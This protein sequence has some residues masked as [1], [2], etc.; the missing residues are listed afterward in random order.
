MRNFGFAAA[1]PPLKPIS[2]RIKLAIVNFFPACIFALRKG[3]VAL[4]FWSIVA[5]LLFALG[6][7]VG[8]PR[9]QH[10]LHFR[11]RRR[12]TADAVVFLLL[13]FHIHTSELLGDSCLGRE[14]SI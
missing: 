7:T 2:N 11:T 4:D 3:G 13:N 14:L 12:I 8:T 1:S 5:C 6:F 10:F 9:R